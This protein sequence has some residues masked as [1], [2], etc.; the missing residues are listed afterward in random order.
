VFLNCSTYLEFG[1]DSCHTKQIPE[2]IL[3]SLAT[4]VLG[5]AEFDEAAFEQQ[6]QEI[7]ALDH[8]LLIFVF[9][10][11]RTIQKQWQHKSRRESWSEEAR[12]RARERQLKYLERRNSTC[13]Q[14]EQ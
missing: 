14:Q 6:I 5:L 8:N 7:K 3:H 10:D 1:R 4:E 9:H 13:V 12:Q 11:G 2:A